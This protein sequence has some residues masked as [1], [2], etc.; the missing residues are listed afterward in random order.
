MLSNLYSCGM[1]FPWRISVPNLEELS[2]G[3]ISDNILLHSALRSERI[4]EIFIPV[5][6]KYYLSAGEWQ[7]PLG[8]VHP[9]GQKLHL[10]I[11]T[12]DFILENKSFSAET[13]AQ[14]CTVLLW[15]YFHYLKNKPILYLKH[16][17]QFLV[18]K[19]FTIIKELENVIHWMGEL[20]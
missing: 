20:L 15:L 2:S 10:R 6:H 5:V 13:F 12:L 16:N 17:Q 19:H 1:D 14:I 9:N 8:L 18:I 4:A 3:I 7:A 11:C